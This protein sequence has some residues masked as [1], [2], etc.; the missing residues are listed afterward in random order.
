MAITNY[1]ELK[2]EII[3]WSHRSDQDLNIDNFIRL[4]EVEMYNHPQKSLRLREMELRTTL[5]MSTASRFLALP[6]G[7]EKMRS[8]RIN[9]TDDYNEL[10]STTPEGLNRRDGTGQPLY[11]TVTSQLE[12]DILPDE[13]YEV[14][15]NYYGTPT[16]I[17]A[18]NTTN[19]VLTANPDIYLFGALYKLFLR[20][21]DAE[22]AGTYQAMF[23]SAIR[24]ANKA[25]R[26]GRFG[27]LPTIEVDGPT[28]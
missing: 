8:M 2:A 27:V 20:V 15:L 7:F 6:T 11:F 1:S 23:Y 9:V 4:A 12:F 3:G 24:G 28:P 17:S 10:L 25:A 26:A 21:V 18:A 19:A 16:G 14:E 22:Q 13:A 5:T